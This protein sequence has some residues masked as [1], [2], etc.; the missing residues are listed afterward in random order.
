GTTENG[1]MLGTLLVGTIVS[2]IASGVAVVAMLLPVIIGI[3]KR[4]QIS[5]SRQLIPLA[6]AA[7]FGGNLTLVGAASNV[8]VSGQMEGLGVRG[9]TF[10]EI[11]KVGIPVMIAAIL[12]FMTI[13]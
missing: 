5:T 4:A 2:S 1:L 8:V 9:L 11:A 3:S 10:F 7:S 12:Y 13:G 6:F